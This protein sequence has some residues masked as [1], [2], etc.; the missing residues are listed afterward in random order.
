MDLKL[1][2]A[3]GILVCQTPESSLKHHARYTG[4]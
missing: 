3:V 2:G 4:T 1:A